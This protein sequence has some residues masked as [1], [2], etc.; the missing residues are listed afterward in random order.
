M[1][2]KKNS[3]NQK[4]YQ[5]LK[6]LNVADA[7]NGFFGAAVYDLCGGVGLTQKQQ[8]ILIIY[9]VCQ[10]NDW[11]FTTVLRISFPRLYD[12]LLEYLLRRRFSCNMRISIYWIYSVY[13]KS[14]SKLLNFC[15]SGWNT[16]S[17]A[18]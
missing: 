17:N 3:L 12:Y 10:Q 1:D 9:Q 8:A 6:T 2:C 18:D 15:A 13:S 14:Y 5:N 7:D 4:I 11:N 16:D